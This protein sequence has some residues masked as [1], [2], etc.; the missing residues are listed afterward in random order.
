MLARKNDERTFWDSLE[1]RSQTFGWLCLGWLSLRESGDILLIFP[2]SCRTRTHPNTHLQMKED[3]HLLCLKFHLFGGF[4]FLIN[5]KSQRTRFFLW[6]FEFPRK[7]LLK[8]LHPSVF[9]FD[10]SSGT[11]RLSSRTMFV[12]FALFLTL[13]PDLL[14]TSTNYCLID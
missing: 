11:V 7:G 8:L 5:W 13:Q 10:H 6:P 9:L 2:F 3:G 1:V 12:S 14:W 4:E